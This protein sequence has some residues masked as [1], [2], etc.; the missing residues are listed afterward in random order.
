MARGIH[1]FPSR[2]QKLS[3]FAPKVLGWKRPGRI[4]RCRIPKSILL[5]LRGGVLFFAFRNRDGLNRLAP[6]GYLPRV[7]AVRSF[8]HTPKLHNHCGGK[9][10]EPG[11]FYHHCHID[12]SK[13]AHVWFAC[14]NCSFLTEGN[15]KVY[16]REIA[17][18]LFS[19]TPVVLDL[20]T[21]RTYTPVLPHHRKIVANLGNTRILPN[22]S[23]APIFQAYVTR[24]MD[25][26]GIVPWE[27]CRQEGNRWRLA[28]HL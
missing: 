13:G 6:E 16:I 17:E 23:W 10:T 4:G 25:E 20:D 11:E 7:A 28:F 26:L 5:R 9:W 21:G 2:T 1:L 27:G 12:G 19:Q 3:P 18:R 15:M 24:I 14:C 22:F 8:G